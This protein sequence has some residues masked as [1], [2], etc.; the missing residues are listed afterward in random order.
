MLTGRPRYI[1]MRSLC[2]N[3]LDS[4]WMGDSTTETTR[5]SVDKMIEGDLGHATEMLSALWEIANED[6][7]AGLTPSNASLGASDQR[8]TTALASHDQE[9]T[10]GKGKK[11]NKNK[12]E[13]A[14][15]NKGE[16]DAGNKGEKSARNKGRKATNK[17]QPTGIMPPALQPEIAKKG[18]GIKV[19]SNIPR[20]VS[21]SRYYLPPVAREFSLH[22]TRPHRSRLGA[23]RTGPL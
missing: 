19:P 20:A 23:P 17:A 9:D 22:M 6:D 7:D 10:K 3:R 16:K 21:W 13:N 18:G 2:I 14:A 5:A 8:D 4:I 15:R 11:K 12:G 1:E